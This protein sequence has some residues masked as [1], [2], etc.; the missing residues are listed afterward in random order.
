MLRNPR[1]RLLQIWCL[2]RSFLIHGGLSVLSVGLF[3][4]DITPF[5]WA[6]PR[7]VI[8]SQQYLLLQSLW[9]KKQ[10]GNGTLLSLVLF[11]FPLCSNSS[12]SLWSQTSE[13]LLLQNSSN[14]LSRC[15]CPYS[16]FL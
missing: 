3:Y 8:P 4:E 9:G 10:S 13:T 7:D 16:K 1:S 14:Q 5:I 2:V 12:S 6:F 15:C 11:D